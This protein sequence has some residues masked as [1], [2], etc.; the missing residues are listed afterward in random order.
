MNIRPVSDLKNRYTDIERQVIEDGP[1]ILTKNGY[2]SMVVMSLPQY[3][4]LRGSIDAALDAADRQ[5]ATTT[6]RYTHE[7]V[8]DSIRSGLGEDHAQAL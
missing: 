6:V 2:G 4:R 8:F 7:Q 3:E 1:V 5:A